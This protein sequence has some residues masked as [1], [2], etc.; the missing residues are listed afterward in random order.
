[1][2]QG[3]LGNQVGAPRDSDLDGSGL[4]IGSP[5]ELGVVE[6]GFLVVGVVARAAIG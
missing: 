6:S 4:A 5:R 2:D 1:V 3:R